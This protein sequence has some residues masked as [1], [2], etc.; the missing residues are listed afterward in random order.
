MNEQNSTVQKIVKEWL[1]D[2]EF[3]GLWCE[4]CGCE[5]NDLMPCSG[6][7]EYISKCQAGYK[8]FCSTDCE[9]CHRNEWCDMN[10]EFS[11][12]YIAGEK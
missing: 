3:T 7:D 10:P 1:I 11:N 9:T 4:E 6:W 5:L 2:N 8:V 12:W